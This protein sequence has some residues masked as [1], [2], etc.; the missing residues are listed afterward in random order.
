LTLGQGFLSEA[1]QDLALERWRSCVDNCQ[2]ATE[3]AAKSVLAV[4]GPVGRT[5]N[6]AVL[7]RKALAEGRFA[8]QA[9]PA[10]ERIA[11]FARL[12]GPDVHAQSDY[13]DEVAWRTPWEMFTQSDAERALE[14]A[15]EAVRLARR[16]VEGGTA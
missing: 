5:H 9:R 1:R 7:L 16:I 10:V 13:G 15:D 8:S 14:L 4:L 6:P 2:L 12:L 3:N 11:E